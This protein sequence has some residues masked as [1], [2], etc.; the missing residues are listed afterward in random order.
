VTLA[1]WPRSVLPRDRDGRWNTL[2][3]LCCVLW[4]SLRPGEHIIGLAVTVRG[5]EG[6]RVY[7]AG[8]RLAGAEDAAEEAGAA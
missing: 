5:D 1:D 2:I 4:R 3:D 8:G 6:V 7:E